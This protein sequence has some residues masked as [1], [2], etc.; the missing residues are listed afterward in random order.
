MI[1]KR[2][3]KP[4]IFVRR[5]SSAR[6]RYDVTESGRPRTLHRHAGSLRQYQAAEPAGV[7][8]LSN[9]TLQPRAAHGGIFERVI[10]HWLVYR[11]VNSDNYL[12]FW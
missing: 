2:V 6:A 5:R 12:V 7:T 11:G 8:V 1:A 3:R 4:E 9:E 10:A